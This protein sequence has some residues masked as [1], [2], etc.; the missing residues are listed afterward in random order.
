MADQAAERWYRRMRTIEGRGERWELGMYCCRVAVGGDRFCVE[1]DRTADALT[2]ELLA[3]HGLMSIG[4]RIDWA[5][6]GS[7]EDSPVR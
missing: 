6:A 3:A 4:R 1:H 2:A 7:I 5:Y